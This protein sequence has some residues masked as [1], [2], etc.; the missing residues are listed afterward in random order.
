MHVEQIFAMGVLVCVAFGA[1]ARGNCLFQGTWDPPPVLRVISSKRLNYTDHSYPVSDFGED[2]PPPRFSGDASCTLPM[3]LAALSWITALPFI[4]L[5]AFVRFNTL[6]RS[7]SFIAGV[8]TAISS[9]DR[10]FLFL[11]IQSN[12]MLCNRSIQTRIKCIVK[13][14]CAVL[15]VGLWA[16]CSIALVI[17]VVQSDSDL[18]ELYQMSST[19]ASIG[20]L[21]AGFC[22]F[23][24]VRISEYCINLR[25]TLT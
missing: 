11:F 16:I 22:C 5:D 24:W 15:M 25:I 12:L 10:L 8:D 20:V 13:F 19:F 21:C 1:T 9:T 23:G 6:K 3:L 17:F 18:F 14:F 4:V 7:S 2:R